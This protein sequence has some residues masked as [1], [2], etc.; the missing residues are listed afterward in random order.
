MIEDVFTITT[1]SAFVGGTLGALATSYLKKKGENLATKEDF[2]ELL[3][4]LKMTTHETE[5]IKIELTRSN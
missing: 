1:I 3:R 2:D 4:Q 5:S